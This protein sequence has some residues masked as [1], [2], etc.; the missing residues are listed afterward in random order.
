MKRYL[1][2][3]A[4][5]VLSV[6][7]AAGTSNPDSPF[8]LKDYLNESPPVFT[9]GSLTLSCAV[10]TADVAEYNPVQM[11]M[12]EQGVWGVFAG[13]NFRGTFGRKYKAAPPVNVPEENMILV[14]LKVYCAQN[15]KQLVMQGALQMLKQAGG[16]VSG[17]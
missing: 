4:L 6:N 16:E 11:M 15:P 10:F 7:V 3:F 5:S 13:Y 9:R 14:Y 1:M 8:S 12:Y 2:V 17:K